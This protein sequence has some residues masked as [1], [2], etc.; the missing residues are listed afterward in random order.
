[1][2]GQTR[3]LT[4]RAARIRLVLLDVDG[5]L[6]DGSILVHTDGS[7]SKAFHIKDG[8]AMVWAMA[9]GLQIGWLSS[10]PSAATAHRAAE[11]GVRLLVQSRRPKIDSYD[12]IL[13]KQRLDDEQIAFMG[14]DLVDLA[15]LRR[16]GVSAAPADAVPEVRKRVHIVT[17]APGGRGAVRELLEWV[18]RAQGRWE[19]LVTGWLRQGTGIR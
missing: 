6:T 10:R 8:A 13:R 19:P 5:V 7:E 9:A 4:S 18:L 11:L 16:A 2:K 1:M 3:A 14:D 12:E 17:R 15:V